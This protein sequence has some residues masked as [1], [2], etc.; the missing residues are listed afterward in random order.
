MMIVKRQLYD[1]ELYQI[2]GLVRA[3]HG[4]LIYSDNCFLNSIY[5]LNT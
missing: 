2:D 4:H 1:T 3:L 5:N